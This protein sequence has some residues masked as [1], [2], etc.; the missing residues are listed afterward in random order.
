MKHSTRFDTTNSH[1]CMSIPLLQDTTP[2][3]HPAPPTIQS[4]QTSGVEMGSAQVL[5]V[6]PHSAVIQTPSSHELMPSHLGRCHMCI[7]MYVTPSIYDEYCI[8]KIIRGLEVTTWKIPLNI[9]V[10][11]RAAMVSWRGFVDTLGS[12]LVQKV[13]VNVLADA[14]QTNVLCIHKG[15]YWK[16][17]LGLLISCIGNWENRYC[18]Y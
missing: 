17:H 1:L 16:L 15:K 5:H 13:T 9:R 14:I 10:K 12:T 2:T 8:R 4:V 7:D 3:P 11:A 6:A 18:R